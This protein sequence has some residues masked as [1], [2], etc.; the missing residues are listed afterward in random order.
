MSLTNNTNMCIEKHSNNTDNIKECTICYSLE[1]I[2][3]FKVLHDNTHLVCLSCYETL[4]ENNILKCPYCRHSINCDL[5]QNKE[6]QHSNRN[7]NFD[8]LQDY[9][10]NY[11]FEIQLNDDNYVNINDNVNL[12][13]ND[14]LTHR[15]DYY[16][17]DIIIDS[18]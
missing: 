7:S 2:T 6:L 3:S 8:A 10:A 13:V 11:I 15:D 4:R 1:P 12:I 18:L 16:L 14:L 5:V 17:I 9:I